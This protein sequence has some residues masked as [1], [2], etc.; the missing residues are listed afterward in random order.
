MTSWLRRCAVLLLAAALI[1]IAV[2][3]PSIATSGTPAGPSGLQSR[4]GASAAWDTT[5]LQV[6]AT[7]PAQRVYGTDRREHIDYDLVITNSF[8]AP[9]TLTSLVVRGGGRTLLKL[10]GDAV[11]DR[12]RQVTG[13]GDPTRTVPVSGALTT[14]VDVVLP[15]SAGRTVPKRLHHRVRYTFP[16]GAPAGAIIGSKTIRAP[17]LRVDRRAPI[18]IAPPLHGTGWLSANGCCDPDVNHRTT[19]ISAN[20]SYVTPEVFAV[21]YIRVVN[22]RIFKGDGSQNADWFGEGEPIRAATGGRVVSVIDDRPEVPPG[23]GVGG[24]PTVT[25]PRDFG[26]NSVTVRVEPGVFAF[27]AHMQPGS[28]LVKVGER[29]RTGQKIGLLG[30]SGNTSGPHLH[31]GIN[32]GR[33]PLTADSLP[34]EIDRFRF[35]GTAGTATGGEVPVTGKSHSAHREHPLVRSVSDYRR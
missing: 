12:T 1:A 24:N 21:D 27:Y 30:N 14:Y 3:V 20:G 10:K 35:D 16:S 13:F 31:F 9:V 11:A 26:G 32:D 6:A 29:V 15:R 2:L 4:G 23:E 18:E 19:I 25:K 34:F 8:T 22:G 17:D 5:A 28:I 33:N 7:G